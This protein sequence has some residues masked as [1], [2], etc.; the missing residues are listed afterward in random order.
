MIELSSRRQ[1]SK[2]SSA[3]TTNVGLL[4]IGAILLAL[5]NTS[6]AVDGVIEINP[7]CV[8]V[9]CFPG[10]PAGFPV[11]ITE[12]GSYRL[13]GNLVLPDENTTAIVYSAADVSIDFN[14]FAIRGVTECQQNPSTLL[15]GCAQA[16]SG[17]G[18]EALDTLYSTS[19]RVSN[20]T[21]HG[22]G[23][24]AISLSE[25]NNSA[26][27]EDMVIRSSG[28]TGI[29]CKGYCTVRDSRVELSLSHGIHSDP[30]SGVVGEVNAV[31][32]HLISNGGGGVRCIADDRRRCSVIDSTVKFNS[33]I[34]I[35]GVAIARGVLVA[36]NGSAGIIAGLVADSVVRNNGDT[37]VAA[38][39]VRGS[40][41]SGNAGAGIESGGLPGALVVD[42]KISFNAGCGT[43]DAVLVENFFLQ[44]NNGNLQTCASVHLG[45]NHCEPNVGC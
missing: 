28:S 36:Q 31:D 25:P 5:A 38:R 17:R 22:T 11:T 1:S 3:S 8:P 26:V 41:I 40:Y 12:S 42:N 19:L 18:I 20:G 43:W 23:N 15:V 6:M 13:T 35:S 44:N 37:G 10:D 24:R 9:G 7:A 30:D 45:P 29:Y 32:V 16:G 39:V 14:G 4:V 33:G 34:G 2:F 21:I 27:I